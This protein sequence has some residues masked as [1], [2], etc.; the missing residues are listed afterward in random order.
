MN[1]QL[2][3]KVFKVQNY[4]VCEYHWCAFVGICYFSGTWHERPLNK[5]PPLCV[6][7][8]LILWPLVINGTNNVAEEVVADGRFHCISLYVLPRFLYY[9]YISYRVEMIRSLNDGWYY[10]ILCNSTCPVDFCE[11]RANLSLSLW[12]TW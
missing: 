2:T 9:T 7:I 4:V 5:G 12:Q 3:L 1:R 6:N 10:A 11:P 8:M